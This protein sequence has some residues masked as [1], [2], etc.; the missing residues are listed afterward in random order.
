MTI[1]TGRIAAATVATLHAAFASPV[2]MVI[3][4]DADLGVCLD[5]QFQKLIATKPLFIHADLMKGIAADREGLTFLKKEVG[6]S[7]IVS[8]R[9]NVLRLARSAGLLCVQ[10]TFLIDT[11]S[12]E[13]S[14]DALARNP[15]DAV[16][17]MP[18]IA[19]SAIAYIKSRLSIPIIMAGLIK[20]EQDVL[21]A[22][23]AG[24][25]AV[26]MSTAELWVAPP[27]LQ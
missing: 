23:A 5:A 4:L 7:G 15:P 2:P 3:L 8:T 12:L 21:T 22:F 17:F 11:M 6:V 26:S 25:D 10:R 1:F 13:A 18:G 9:A 24:A 14:L 20:N 19:P 27:A 16:E